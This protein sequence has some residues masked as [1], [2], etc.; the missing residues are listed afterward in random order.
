[1]TDQPTY[2]E[3]LKKVEDLERSI[4]TY[5]ALVNNT[6]DLFYRTD[7]E[8]RI[9]YVSPSVFKLSG[10]TVE[11]AVG[12]RMAEEIYLFPE[13]RK[14]FIAKLEQEGS[15]SNFEAQLKRKDGS[16]W[17]A[18]TNAHFY[19]DRDGN[20]GIEG[21]SRDI[22]ERKTA[23]NSL[24]TVEERFRLTFQTSPDAIN[25]NRLSDGMYID[26]NQGFTGLTGYTREDVTGKTSADINIWKNPEDRK[27]LVEGLLKTGFVKNLEARFVRKNG[28]VGIGLMS[29]RILEINNENIILSVTRDIT[30]I[31]QA[32]ATHRILEKQ[33][34]Q[35][36]KLEAIGRLAGGVAHDLNN[37]L[38]PILGYSEMLLFDTTANDPRKR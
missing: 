16:I 37:L 25:L 13:E 18:A 1:M 6:Q 19:K 28:E 12:M 15:V 21:I 33:L 24:R 22:T 38:S 31:R 34:Q 32:E 30:E 2:G 5:R 26:I 23:E 3:L 7:F 27:R 14:A 17:W 20:I 11:E 10:Y 9:S 4:D 29:A 36:Q 8:G 35:A